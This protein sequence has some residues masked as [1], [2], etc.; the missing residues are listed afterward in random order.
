MNK[1]LVIGGSL[2]AFAALLHLGC[3]YFGAPWYRFFGAGE[4]MAQLAEKGSIQ[5]TI[6]TSVIFIILTTWSAYAF[7]AAGLIKKLPLIRLAL[8]LISFI[9]LARGIAG[10]FLI[11][12]PMGRSAEFWLWSSTI[13]LTI[14]LIH[15]FGLRQQWAK[16]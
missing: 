8:I 7:S 13:C 4:E 2:S 16:L 11:Y 15:L 1:Y 14:G 10:F 3:I 9:Y 6:V 5:P 12:Q